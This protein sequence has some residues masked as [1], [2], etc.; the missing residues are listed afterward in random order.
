ML[1]KL[2]EIHLRILY[3]KK[4]IES[5]EI[6]TNNIEKLSSKFSLPP[7][8]DIFLSFIKEMRQKKENYEKKQMLYEET[9]SFLFLTYYK[10]ESSC[11]S[12]RI[13]W[14][15]RNWKKEITRYKQALEVYRDKLLEKTLEKREV[16]KIIT[17]YNKI[18]MVTT[19]LYSLEQDLIKNRRKSLFYKGLEEKML[20]RNMIAYSKLEIEYKE[21]IDKIEYQKERI[22]PNRKRKRSIEYKEYRKKK[23]MGNKK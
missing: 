3:Y 21:L 11:T 15:E 6:S 14:N 1:E 13:D 23:N 19:L 12:G 5:I 7:K 9:L 18:Q 2:K 22:N 4:E 10:M 8:E 17:D 16:S 20:L